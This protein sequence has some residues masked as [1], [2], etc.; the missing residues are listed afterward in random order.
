MLLLLFVDH[1]LL[2]FLVAGLRKREYLVDGSMES[3]Q[4]I[5]NVVGVVK[6]DTTKVVVWL[7]YR[8]FYF[9]YITY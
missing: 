7:Q 1:H 5:T 4:Q 9:D 3:L 2:V 6:M 8:F